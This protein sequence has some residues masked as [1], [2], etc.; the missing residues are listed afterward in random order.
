MFPSSVLT[1]SSY[2]E[3]QHIDSV[4]QQTPTTEQH[5]HY[6]KI[7]V[8]HAHMWCLPDTVRKRSKRQPSS[9]QHAWVI[10]RCPTR[11]SLAL[12]V[13]LQAA[14]ILSFSELKKKIA[15]CKI[16]NTALCDGNC[17]WGTRLSWSI[18]SELHRTELAQ[19]CPG[20]RSLFSWVEHLQVQ[21]EGQREWMNI[22]KQQG[23]R[24]CLVQR[25]D[26]NV[27]GREAGGNEALP[28]Y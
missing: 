8:K 23:H 13:C 28:Q 10:L 1:H 6:Q 3:E 21:G 25:W 26:R 16:S 19:C 20:Q 15:G 2:A 27:V 22:P 18:R 4:A 12:F 7:L 14:Q 24:I 17:L 9:T 11:L 5:S